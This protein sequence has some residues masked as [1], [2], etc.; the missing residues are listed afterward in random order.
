MTSCFLL[1]YLKTEKNQ[2][3]KYQYQCPGSVLVLCK[4]SVAYIFVSSGA[5]KY[6]FQMKYSFTYF[7]SQS[8]KNANKNKKKTTKIKPP[9]TH[10]HTHTWSNTL[11][12]ISLGILLLIWIEFEVR[13]VGREIYNKCVQQC[14]TF[15]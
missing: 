6:E 4:F 10:K 15:T 5:R 14:I 12:P 3:F 9:N 2:T 13:G 1:F 7:R 8:T 11:F